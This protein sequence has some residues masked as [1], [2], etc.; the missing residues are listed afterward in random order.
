ML[1]F[2]NLKYVLLYYALAAQGLDCEINHSAEKTQPNNKTNKPQNHNKTN[3][4]PKPT[5]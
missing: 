5:T 3:K 1:W 2:C 4:T